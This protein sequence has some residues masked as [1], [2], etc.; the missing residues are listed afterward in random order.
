MEKLWNTI[1]KLLPLVALYPKWAQT[2]FL[3]TFALLLAS[4]FVFIVQYPSVKKA[5]AGPQVE[6]PP[7]DVRISIEQTDSQV[8]KLFADLGAAS[9][10]LYASSTS[11]R[12]HLLSYTTARPNIQ[13]Y[14]QEPLPPSLQNDVTYVISSLDRV[15]EALLAINQNSF[16]TETWKSAGRAH[17]ADA[18]AYIKT[19]LM[20]EGFSD[21]EATIPISDIPSIA[22]FF[23]IASSKLKEPTFGS[24]LTAVLATNSADTKSANKAY[25]NTSLRSLMFSGNLLFAFVEKSKLDAQKTLVASFGSAILFDVLKSI[26]DKPELRIVMKDRFSRFSKYLDTYPF[27]LESSRF[28]STDLKMAADELEKRKD[29]LFLELR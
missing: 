8:T 21:T 4:A 11:L 9:S 20:Q 19:K 1:E 29:L 27:G 6:E 23:L 22:Q 5:A 17:K 10:D 15:R 26:P 12:L 2:L 7:S 13:E 18:L 28:V 24:I 3:T 14:L 25:D 16:A